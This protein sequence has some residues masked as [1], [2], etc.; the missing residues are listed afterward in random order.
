MFQVK[1]ASLHG[2]WALYELKDGIG[3]VK[4]TFLLS[5]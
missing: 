5:M 3:K 1:S 4:Q 2:D